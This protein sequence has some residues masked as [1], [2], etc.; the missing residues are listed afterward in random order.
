MSLED[1]ILR[2]INGITVLIAGYV[3]CF[4]VILAVANVL[5]RWLFRMPLPS[6]IEMTWLV[7]PY[8]SFLPM[9]YTF[10]KGQ[11][12]S[13]TALTDKMSLKFQFFSKIFSYILGIIYFAIIIYGGSIYF[14]ESFSIRETVSTTIPLPWYVAKF[15]LPVGALLFFAA[16]IIELIRSVKKYKTKEE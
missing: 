13:I 1:N 7:F 14:L 5:V 16:L 15:A 4:I 2:K 3:L 10:I 9:A 8:V 11:H 12:I 6:T